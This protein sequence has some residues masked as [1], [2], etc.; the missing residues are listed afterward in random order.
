MARVYIETSVPSFYH[1]SRADPELV[2]WREATRRWW[3]RYGSAYELC[4][5]IVTIEEL[6]AAPPAK[7]EPCLA[8][9]RDV[10]LLPMPDGV[11][12]VIEYYVEQQLMPRGPDAAHVAIASMHRVDFLLT[13][14]CRHIANANKVR[15]LGVLNGRLGIPVPVLTTPLGLVPENEP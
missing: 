11:G 6:K 1:E 7:S 4:T 5:S 13:W 8:M 14:N 2:A 9:L 15:H 12:E 3:D 10:E